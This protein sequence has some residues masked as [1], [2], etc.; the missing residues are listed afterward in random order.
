MNLHLGVM[1][2]LNLLI[3]NHIASPVWAAEALVK[4]AHVS[5]RIMDSYSRTGRGSYFSK[6]IFYDGLEQDLDSGIKWDNEGYINRDSVSKKI[7]RQVRPEVKKL[8][9][10]MGVLVGRQLSFGN[11]GWNKFIV[12]FKD[13]VGK[14]NY[15]IESGGGNAIISNIAVKNKEGRMEGWEISDRF[16]GGGTEKTVYRVSQ[17]YLMQQ[18]RKQN[19]LEWFYKMVPKSSGVGLMIIRKD[20]EQNPDDSSDMI[21]IWIHLEG[22]LYNKQ[23][24]LSA[25]IVIGWKHR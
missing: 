24:L 2:F 7:F 3:V 4:I 12:D 13:M 9:P 22:L 16:L 15:I 11:W 10:D 19:A 23:D 5:N 18:L 14:G 20:Y 25:S 8:L 17:T 21:L 6:N 1:L